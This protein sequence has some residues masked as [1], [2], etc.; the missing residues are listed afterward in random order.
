MFSKTISND[1]NSFL[2]VSRVRAEIGK[3]VGH[4]LI[5]CEVVKIIWS[6]YDKL[7][8][9]LFCAQKCQMVPQNGKLFL[10]FVQSYYSWTSTALGLWGIFCIHGILKQIPLLIL[11]PSVLWV[12]VL[13]KNINLC[14][15]KYLFSSMSQKQ[16]LF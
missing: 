2:L 7:I 3:S 14:H 10:L 5:C 13:F 9:F 1:Y 15:T 8:F 4:L 16:L 6:I 12:Q 11:P